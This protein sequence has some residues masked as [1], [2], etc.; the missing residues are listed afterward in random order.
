[1]ADQ[2]LEDALNNLDLNEDIKDTFCDPENP[3][4]V[5]FPEVSAASYKIKGGVE[6]TP[7][8]VSILQICVNYLKKSWPIKNLT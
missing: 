4:V 8:N 2:S 7:C 6:R 3:V 1:M 5:H